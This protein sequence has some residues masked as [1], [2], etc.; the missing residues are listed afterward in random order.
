MSNVS[1]KHMS[2]HHVQQTYRKMTKSI[3]STYPGFHRWPSPETSETEALGRAGGSLR[4]QRY[5]LLPPSCPGCSPGDWCAGRTGRPAPR[6]STSQSPGTPSTATVQQQIN[7]MLNK[8]C[9]RSLAINKWMNEWMNEW[10]RET[11]F[12]YSTIQ[13]LNEWTNEQMNRWRIEHSFIKSFR[14]WNV[15]KKAWKDEC[16]FRPMVSE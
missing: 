14:D 1:L 16:M 5:P 2:Q 9:T 8:Q 15:W 7:G 4:W 11:S 10:M 6:H 13:G 3:I 12:I